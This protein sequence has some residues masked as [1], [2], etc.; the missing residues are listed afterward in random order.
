MSELRSFEEQN[1]S[2]CVLGLLDLFFEVSHKHL[3]L[4]HEFLVLTLNSL[5]L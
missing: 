3:V 4:E 5:D 2:V 1:E